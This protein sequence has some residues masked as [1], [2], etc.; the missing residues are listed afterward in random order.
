MP[1]EGTNEELERIRE[2][3]IDLF[4]KKID[5]PIYPIPRS[6]FHL[7][8]KYRAEA[9]LCSDDE[10]KGFLLDISARLAR[11][12][13]D[14]TESWSFEDLR[15]IVKGYAAWMLDKTR[16]GLIPPT[17]EGIEKYTLWAHDLFKQERDPL[18]AKD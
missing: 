1:F 8:N 7:M 9:N 18:S 16:Q 10:R 13:H 5:T 2:F 11:V 4:T 17:T 3:I 12:P 15:M 14:V 6:S